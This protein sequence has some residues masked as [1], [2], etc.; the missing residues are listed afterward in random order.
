MYNLRLKTHSFSFNVFR[1]VID[2]L[3]TLTS[4]MKKYAWY[5]MFLSESIII[6]TSQSPGV[7]ITLST[8]INPNPYKNSNASK[9]HIIPEDNSNNIKNI[10]QN[11]R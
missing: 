1:V 2:L 6:S 3:G 7:T 5:I 9:V 11:K 10:K 4:S 8:I